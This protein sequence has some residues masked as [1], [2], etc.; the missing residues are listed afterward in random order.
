MPLKA[1]GKAMDRTG[2]SGDRPPGIRVGPMVPLGGLRKKEVEG[3]EGRSRALPGGAA[4]TNGLFPP[5]EV[6]SLTNTVEER[7]GRSR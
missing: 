3:C 2:E 4:L 7:A 5:S 1:V 6:K